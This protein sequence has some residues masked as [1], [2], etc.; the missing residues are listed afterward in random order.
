M[1]G[2]RCSRL[3][4]L[5]TLA[6][7]KNNPACRTEV[8]RRI[9]FLLFERLCIRRRGGAPDLPGALCHGPDG[10]SFHHHDLPFL[11]RIRVPGDERLVHLEERDV[12]EDRTN[13]KERQ[14][15]SHEGSGNTAAKAVS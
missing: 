14:C 3:A 12:P 1:T 5:T 10:L 9:L 6:S 15:L 13:R 7:C 2:A 11:D 4:S 8:D